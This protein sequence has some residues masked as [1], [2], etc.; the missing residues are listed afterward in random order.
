MHAVAREHRPSARARPVVMVMVVRMAVVMGVIVVC[1]DVAVGGGLCVAVLMPVVPQLGLV[2]QEEK[3]HTHQQ[4]GKQVVGAR[5]ALERLGQQMH[6]G[7]GQ[8]GARRQAQQ[9]LGAHA[10]GA[11]AQAQP[12]QQCG[13]PHAANAR[14]QRG[15]DDCY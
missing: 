13:Q 11:P 1:M 15:Q 9:V 7:R 6:E 5:L 14:S 8:Q 12:H 2:Q 4:G 10:V 3:H